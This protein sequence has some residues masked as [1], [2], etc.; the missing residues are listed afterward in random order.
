MSSFIKVYVTYDF[1]KNI[2]RKYWV[3]H[4]NLVQSLME[5]LEIEDAFDDA[6]MRVWEK[7]AGDE[8]WL[9]LEKPLS[10]TKV[11]IGGMYNIGGCWKGR[12]RRRLV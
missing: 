1:D 8:A 3:P 9:E 5:F 12:L 4:G 2:R 7:L 11:K 6:T 10:R